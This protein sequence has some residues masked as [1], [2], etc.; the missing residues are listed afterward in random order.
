MAKAQK[1][2][3]I[4][5]TTNSKFSSMGATSCQKIVAILSQYYENV[6]VSIIND[7]SDLEQLV[8]DR[9]DLVFLGLKRLP[10]SGDSVDDSNDDVWISDYLDQNNITYTGASAHAMKLEFNKEKAKARV[11]S[12]GLPTARS[13]ISAPGRHKYA[14]SLPLP[15]PLFIKPLN[16]GCGN[17]V[18]DNSVVRTFAEF[19]DKVELVHINNSSSSLV[20]Q[21]LNG[22]EFSVAILDADNAGRIQ[23]APIEIIASKNSRGDRILGSR[24]KTENNEIVS[25]I[26]E[27]ETY[28]AVSQLAVQVYKVLCG[29]DLARIDIRMDGDGKLQFLEA[30]FM[31][32]PGSRYFAGAF[33]LNKGTSY[34]EVLLSITDTALSRS[35]NSNVAKLLTPN[36]ISA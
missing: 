36:L 10:H 28:N 21:Y 34:E 17:G 5:R 13:F 32:A 3:E 29:R 30:N 26:K 7:L 33:E 31:P 35:S 12:A 8:E 24:V 23:V 14:Q 6:G 9:P 20:E 18:G 1:H 25:V 2:V 11:R 27:P 19:G 15:F 22:R 4:A 16:G